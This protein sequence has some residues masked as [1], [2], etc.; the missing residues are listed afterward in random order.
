MKL[1]GLPTREFGSCRVFCAL[2]RWENGVITC[3]WAWK[4]SSKSENS[5]FEWSLKVLDIGKSE[6]SG[7][8]L[9][10]GDGSEELIGGLS[11]RDKDIFDSE[12]S[13][14]ESK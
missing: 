6:T 7:K 3:I 5:E 2:N 10:S 9:V 13:E 12:I 8:I 11:K 1:W 14:C 4:L